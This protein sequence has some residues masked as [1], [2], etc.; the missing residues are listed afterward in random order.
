MMTRK[1]SNIGIAMCAA[2]LMMTITMCS[3]TPQNVKDVNAEAKIYPDYAGVTI[4]SNIA[5]LNF[6]IDNDS[7]TCLDVTI[8][9]SKGGKI[10]SNGQYTD[11]DVDEWHKLCEANKGDSLIVSVIAKKND[12]WT[13][14]KDFSIYISDDTMEACGL[15]YRRIAPGYEVYGH[16]GIYQRDLSNFEEESIMDN[17]EVYGACFN[18]HT[19]NKTSNQDYLFHVRGDNAA[20]IVNHNGKTDILNTKTDKTIGSLVYPYWHPDGRYVAFSSNTTRQSFH[21]T[22]DTRIE[23]FDNES[24][25]MVYDTEKQEILFTPLTNNT[26]STL[27]TFPAFSADGKDIFFCAA[28]SNYNPAS[29]KDL[30]YDLCKISFDAEKRSFGSKVDTVIKMSTHGKS[31]SHPRPSYD[32]RYL[33]FTVSDFGTFPIWH[34]EADLW[35]LDLQTGKYWPMDN[36]N[37][38]NTDS[39][40]NWSIDSHWFV[41]TSRRDDGLYTRLYIA[42]VDK[43]GKSSKPFL[44]PQ[45]N[46][47]RYYDALLD[48]YN[49]PDFLIAKISQNQKALASKLLSPERTNI[50]A[51]NV[52]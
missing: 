16:M 39:Y 26:D 43:N 25:I 9:G 48:S 23:V 3:E 29:M 30:W 32:G 40:H 31:I 52:E 12:I 22:R 11:F 27:E 5:P 28:S 42:H 6:C 20:T 37:S 15:T 47:K 51:V 13:K 7:V 18:C 50:E 8:K 10:E 2:A 21:M 38:D 24:D 17:N 45:R 34:K 36:A 4:P 49:T 19:G 44:L 46:P 33:M 1:H 14:Y 35:M 41:F